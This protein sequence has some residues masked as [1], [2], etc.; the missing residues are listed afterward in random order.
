LDNDP[1]PSFCDAES[2]EE[3]LTFITHLWNLSHRK[4]GQTHIMSFC[5]S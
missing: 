1:A 4:L 2:L 5:T 3:L